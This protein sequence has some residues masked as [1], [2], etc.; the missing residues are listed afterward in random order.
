MADELLYPGINGGVAAIDKRS[1]DPYLLAQLLAGNHFAGMCEEYQQNLEGLTGQA[2]SNASFAQ[3]GGTSIHFKRSESQAGLG[4]GCHW[5][6]LIRVETVYYGVLP[7][8]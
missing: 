1:G 7:G 3:L 8:W 6:S 2:D 4:L 5:Q